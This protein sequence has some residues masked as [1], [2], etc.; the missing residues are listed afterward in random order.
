MIASF[1]GPAT[2]GVENSTGTAGTAYEGPIFSGLVV[3][4][5]YQAVDSAPREL[6]FTGTVIDGSRMRP[7]SM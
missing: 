7:R 2:V 3:C 6:S 4:F 5:D 1:V